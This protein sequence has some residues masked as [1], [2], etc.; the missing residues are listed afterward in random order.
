MMITIIVLKNYNLK[1][2]VIITIPYNVSDMKTSI[3]LIIFWVLF[4]LVKSDCP[5]SMSDVSICIR[6]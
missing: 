4:V 5:V 2:I 6:L 3:Y 1:F